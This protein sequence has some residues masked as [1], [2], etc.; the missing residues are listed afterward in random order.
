MNRRTALAKPTAQTPLD[1]YDLRA[2]ELTAHIL[3][4]LRAKGFV[5]WAQDNRGR[6]NPKTGKWYPHPNNRVGVPDII[7][8]RKA[9]ARFIGVEVKAGKDRLSQFQIDFLDELKEHGGFPFV[10]FDFAGFVQLFERRG[11]HRVAT[12]AT[13]SATAATPPTTSLLGLTTYIEP[14]LYRHD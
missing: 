7:G 1:L 2:D 4:Y 6:Y 14:V 9:D 10:A 12:T 5:A 11:L 3:S 13:P 8:Y